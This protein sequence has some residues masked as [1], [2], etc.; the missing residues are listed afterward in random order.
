MF[1][2]KKISVWCFAIGMV[3]SNVFASGIPVVDVA[4]NIQQITSYIQDIADYAEQLNQ[5][6]VQTQQYTQM[7]DDFSQT[8]TEYEHYL[9]QLEGIKDKF[10]NAE[11]DQIMAQTLNTYGSGPM[12]V[13][14][15]M[16][17]A[18]ATYD[19][20]LDVVLANYGYIPEN[21]ND[22]VNEATINGVGDTSR[23]LV[24]A[25]R[26]QAAFGKWR[27]VQ[28]QV[29]DNE[30][31]ALSRR[32]VMRKIG[33][34][35]NSLGDESDLATLQLMANQSQIMM[36]QNEATARTLN[37]MLQQQSAVEAMEASRKAERM[38]K[39]QARLAKH[40]ASTMPVA[41]KDRW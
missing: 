5:L 37:Q 18:S 12:S 30:K 22:V 7:M 4:S 19:D 8:L 29:A 13:I 33:E 14:P 41:G 16:D 2:K 11:W 39:E 3:S 10:T 17:T 25:Q 31:A 32:Q 26:N 15:T 36:D 23:L 38:K 1:L 24:Q 40:R 35:I 6:S 9:K 34:K 21:P 20:D 27:N 28:K